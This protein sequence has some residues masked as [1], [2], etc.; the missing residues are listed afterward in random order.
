MNKEIKDCFDSAKKDE[1]KG[2]KHKGLII[3]EPSTEKAKDYLDKARD[4]LKFCQNVL[5]FVFLGF[6]FLFLPF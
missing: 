1:E 6:L 4:S 3:V 2:K 5:L